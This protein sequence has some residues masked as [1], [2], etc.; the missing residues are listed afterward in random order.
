MRSSKPLTLEQAQRVRDQVTAFVKPDQAQLAH[1][2]LEVIDPDLDVIARISPTIVRVLHSLPKLERE[3][4]IRDLVTE[5]QQARLEG[6][7]RGKRAGRN[8][9]I[10]T[11]HE[12]LGIDRL[13]DAIRDLGPT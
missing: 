10:E 11:V 6:Y 3:S 1:G 8:E 5:P 9:L 4:L 7:A 2:G 12:L 13:A